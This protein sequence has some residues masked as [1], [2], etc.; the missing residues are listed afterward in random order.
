MLEQS[1]IQQHSSLVNFLYARSKLVRFLLLL[2]QQQQQQFLL[3]LL[4]SFS[5]YCSFQTFFLLTLN[6][7]PSHSLS[8]LTAVLNQRFFNHGVVVNVRWLINTY[9]GSPRIRTVNL[10]LLLLLLLHMMMWSRRIQHVLLLIIPSVTVHLMVLLLLV[11]VRVAPRVA[12]VVALDSRAHDQIHTPVLIVRGPDVV[13]AASTS[14]PLPVVVVHCLIR[15]LLLLLLL[16]HIILIL[17]LKAWDSLLLL[18]L[19]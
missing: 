8:L 16:S 18:L 6:T 3:P 13:T 12:T 9:V 10:M 2:L 1:I 4:R 19:H 14:Y 5:S 15:H 7:C 17:L 11:A